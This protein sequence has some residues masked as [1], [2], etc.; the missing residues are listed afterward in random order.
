MAKKCIMLKIAAVLLCLVL[1]TTHLTTGLYAKYTA[2]ASAEDGARVASF[3]I[4]TDLDYIQLGTSQGVS[5]V[6]QL[7]GTDETQ[8][9]S[10]PF[11]IE[12]ASEVAVGYSVTVDF[13]A[14][15]PSYMSLTLSN[16]TK[17][18]ALTG[19]G[20]KSVFTFTDFGIM[21]PGGETAQTQELT[22]QISISDL[23]MITDEVSI[24]TAELTVRVYQVD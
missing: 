21:A 5:P 10:I 3:H 1:I 13:G 4:D 20:T 2:V 23:E 8:S 16:G 18:E 19:D 7:G 11:F 24:P 22:L 15:L 6:F 14:A 17:T 9:I 12:S